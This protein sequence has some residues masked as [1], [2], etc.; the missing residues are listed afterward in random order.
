MDDGFSIPIGGDLTPLHEAVEKIAAAFQSVSESINAAFTK[1]NTAVDSATSKVQAN[2]AAAM[3]STAANQQAGRAMKNYA[4]EVN[5][6][7]SA[8]SNAG[9]AA[10]GA[11]AAISLMSK[12]SKVFT[13][14][15]LGAKLATVVTN[16]GGVRNA[17]AKIPAAMSAVAKNPTLRKI[18]IGAA[19]ASAAVL[20]IRGAWKA[21]GAGARVLR[22]AAASSY[23]A[24]IAGAQ[25]A[26]AVVA[27]LFSKISALPGK[28][29]MAIPGLPFAG[30]VGG[31]GGIAA[32]TTLAFSAINKAAD[33]ESLE[34]AFVPLLGGIEES[35][36]RIS[37]LTKFSSR[38]NFQ[39][40]EVAEG[41]RLLEVLTAG[42]LSTG[43]AL[44]MVGDIAA[45]TR[46]PFQ[47]MAMWVGRLYDGLQSG[48]PVG[49][50]M[51]RLQELGVISGATRAEIEALQE[52]GAS[53]DAVW[54]KAASALG[55]FSGS[56]E[57]QSMTWRGKLSTIRDEIGI[58]LAA[59]GR[60]IIDG[61]K[62]FLDMALSKIRSMQ[63][64]AAAFG[65]KIKKAL[66]AS[67]AAIQTG[68]VLKVFGAGLVLAMMKGVNALSSGI[69]KAF[70]YAGSFLSRIMKEAS[71]SWNLQEIFGI[72]MDLGKALSAS[73]TAAILKAIDTIPGIDVSTDAQRETHSA[74]N[75]LN[76][77]KNRIEDLDGAQAIT[78]LAEASKRAHH[79]AR[80]DSAKAGDNPIFDTTKAEGVFRGLAGILGIQITLHEEN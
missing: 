31:L 41:S 43:P 34:T 47:E 66:N 39:L 53:G 13:G 15:T 2:A 71:D 49:D 6:F 61:L 79:G 11:A 68:N 35:Q 40:P 70:T 64:E 51:M 23:R 54:S 30:I 18:V 69:R 4:A 58:T 20:A 52:S 38:T 59:F 9:N 80:K 26:K 56:M 27:G 19:A 45:G 1:A 57:R 75:S 77:A 7:L 78:E 36:K 28:F 10:M 72:M 76:R 42:A 37:E 74:G 12:A 48:R 16:A 29:A 63:D 5:G 55:R 21:A 25:R 17:F 65:L 73:I 14:V 22:S 44:R 24:V 46:R 67:L 50:A 3:K 8:A 32:A 33:M 60:P 62:P